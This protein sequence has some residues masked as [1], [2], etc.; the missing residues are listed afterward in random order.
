MN[1]NGAFNVICNAALLMGQN[2]PNEDGQRGVIVN[3][4]ATAAFE[5][6]TG[7]AAFAAASAGIIG[8]TLPIANDLC[9]QGIRVVTI[10]PGFFETPLTGYLPEEV[11][12]Y[13]SEAT[14]SPPRLGKPFEFAHLVQSIVENPL[15]N[16]VTIRLDGGLR[17]SM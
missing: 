6:Q 1:T 14:P 4:S 9:S 8:M 5:G 10:A 15:L 3:T 2:T 12:Q 7:Q 17:F 16:G 13:L 11:H